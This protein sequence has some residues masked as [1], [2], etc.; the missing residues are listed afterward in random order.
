MQ[1]GAV[2]APTKPW[3]FAEIHLSG[4]H[5]KARFQQ[6]LSHKTSIEQ[7]VGTLDWQELPKKQAC[8]I[9]RQMADTDSTDESDW[10][11]Q[12]EWLRDTL[13]AFHV[14]FSPFVKQLQDDANALSE[15]DEDDNAFG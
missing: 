4:A 1:L 7:Q 13:K 2:I 10:K 8:R 14:A 6:L 5:A 9:K 3:I 12:H 11:R 15:P